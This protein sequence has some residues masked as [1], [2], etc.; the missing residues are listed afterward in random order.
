MTQ[1]FGYNPAGQIT[2]RTL[3]NDSFAFTNHVNVD[4][5]YAAN[6]LN[7]YTSAGS[8]S[9]GYDTKGNLTDGSVTYSYDT[10]NR[11]T[12]ASG[13][14]TASLLYDPLGR[15]GMSVTVHYISSR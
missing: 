15:L 1:S 13:A 12:A 2:T 11:L 14:K 7:Q 4:R 8:A 9:F 10:E 3:S 6:G 5:S